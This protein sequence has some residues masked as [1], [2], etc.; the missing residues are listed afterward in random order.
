MICSE[1]DELAGAFALGALPVAEAAEFEQHLATC[2]VGHPGLVDLLEVASLLPFA[3]DEVEPP[4]RLRE[5]LIAAALADRADR[6]SHE[7]PAPAPA[8]GSSGGGS[9]PVPLAAARRRRPWASPGIWAAA[10]LLLLAVGLGVWNVSL[11]RDLDDKTNAS[12]RQARALATLM[13]GA[14][15]VPV[16]GQNGLRMLLVQ[17]PDGSASL[18]LGNLPPPPAGKVYQAWFIRDGTPV[19]AGV[20]TADGGPVVPLQGS[21]AGAQLVAVTIEPPGGSPQPTSD[22]IAKAPLG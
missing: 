21:P 9:A 22:I 7:P 15:V 14:Q 11:R 3:A 17:N 10:A 1:I 6:Q 8:V 12:N 5:N 19:G 20:F 2:A 18:V 16:T 13:A 4:A